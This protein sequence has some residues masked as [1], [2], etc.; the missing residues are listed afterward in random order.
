MSE[1]AR[2]PSPAE[3]FFLPGKAGRLF[4]LYRPAENPA[5][6]TLLIVPAFAEEMNKSRRMYTLLADDLNR[7]GIGV[8]LLDLYGTGDSEGDFVDAR[9][10]TWISD[11]QCALQWL[12]DST[13]TPVSILGHRLGALLALELIGKHPQDFAK[14]IL[15]QPV[16][17]GKNYLTQFLRLR[18]AASMLDSA[19]EKETTQHLRTAL[20]EG[21]SIEVAGY[22]LHQELAQAIDS[23]EFVGMLGEAMPSAYWFDLSS[24]ET[25]AMSPAS[26]KHIS[27]CEEK[28]IDI[29]SDVIRGDAFW[30][31]VEIA[32]VPALIEKTCGVFG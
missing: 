23:K 26:R 5:K 6:E 2:K 7:K 30:S 20:S 24:Q 8:L 10:D 11:L 12:K 32:T 28:G 3:V 19:Q 25:P 9:W 21:K 18:M 14:L 13:N 16:T 29:K 27:A 31:T 15:W 17:R 1:A 22:L 4:T